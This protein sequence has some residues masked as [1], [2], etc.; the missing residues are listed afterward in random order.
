MGLCCQLL[1]DLLLQSGQACQS[2]F[3]SLDIKTLEY[4]AATDAEEEEKK[5]ET[6]WYT[7]H[8]NYDA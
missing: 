1:Y 2:T 5:R 8:T 7:V 6:A 4:R 3:L